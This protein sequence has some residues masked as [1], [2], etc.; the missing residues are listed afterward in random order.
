M[1][2][3]PVVRAGFDFVSIFLIVG[4][5]IDFLPKIAAG[6]SAAYY[7]Y[8]IFEKYTSRKNK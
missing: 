7:G 6:V 5:F 3:N 2:H 1:T 4:T 8:L